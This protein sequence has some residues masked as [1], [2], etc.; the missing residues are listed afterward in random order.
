MQGA[1]G[2]GILEVT[3]T[4]NGEVVASIE[5]IDEKGAEQALHNASQAYNYGVFA[6][7]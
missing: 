2:K 7:Q 3:L 5:T 1:S 4:F 6:Y